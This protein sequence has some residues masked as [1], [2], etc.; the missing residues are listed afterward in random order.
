MHFLHDVAPTNEL[1]LDVNLR[2]RRPVGVLFDRGSE[3]FIGEDVDILVFLDS[4]SI[5]E[6]D[7][8][9]AE[10]ALRHFAGAFHEDANIIFGD[11]LRDV[12]SHFIRRLGLRLRLEVI[13]TVFICSSSPIVRTEPLVSSSGVEWLREGAGRRDGSH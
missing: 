7:D 10:A 13:V 2:N 8:V 3:S 4:V 12:L 1:S 6:N 5:Q 9:P 11:P